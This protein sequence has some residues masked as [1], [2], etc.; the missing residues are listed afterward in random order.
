MK[1]ILFS[2]SIPIIFS[3]NISPILLKEFSPKFNLLFFL[4]LFNWSNRYL[5]LLFNFDIFIIF[6]L[7]SKFKL[8]SEKALLAILSI[9]IHLSLLVS[10]ISLA[11][12]KLNEFVI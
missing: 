7:S 8:I 3:F 4:I 5:L 2:L 6:F 9:L 12:F 10:I 1:S 11:F